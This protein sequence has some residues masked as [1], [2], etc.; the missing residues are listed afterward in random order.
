MYKKLLLPLSIKASILTPIAL[1]SASDIQNT[2]VN[3]TT[4]WKENK[5]YFYYETQYNTQMAP[6]QF[7]QWLKGVNGKKTLFQM[8][9]PGTHDS[10]A[11]AGNWNAFTWAWTKTQSM[12]FTQQLNAGIRAFDLRSHANLKLAHGP[13]EM[14]ASFQSALLEMVDFLKKNPSEFIFF[15][16]KDDGFDVK[17]QQNV[18]E[19]ASKYLAIL[20]SDEIYPYLFNPTGI[21]FPNL[22]TESFRLDNLRGKIVIANF[23]YHSIQDKMVELQKNFKAN[24]WSGGFDYWWAF[25]KKPDRTQD[26][27]NSSEEQKYQYATAFMPN[28]NNAP[29]DT[30]NLYINFLSVANG[31]RPPW[32]AESLNPRFNQFFI[33]NQQ[34]HKMGLVYADFPGPSLIENIFKTNYYVTNEQLKHGYELPWNNK[35]TISKPLV[36]DNKITVYGDNLQGYTIEVNEGNNK[37][38]TVTI[39]ENVKQKTIDLGNSY[40]LPLNLDLAVTGYRKT[41]ENGFYPSRKYNVITTNAKIQNTT[42]NQQSQELTSKV[43]QYINKLKSTFGINTFSTYL[44]AQYLNKLQQYIR[45]SEQNASSI[46]TL[47]MQFDKEATKLDLLIQSFNQFKTNVST[48]IAQNN[49]SLLKILNQTLINSLNNTF[50]NY[51]NIIYTSI[52]SSAIDYDDLFDYFDEYLNFLNKLKDNIFYFDNSLSTYLAYLKENL[53]FKDYGI[54]YWLQ[55]EQVVKN[56]LVDFANLYQNKSFLNIN[57]ISRNITQSI[58]TLKNNLQIVQNDITDLNALQEQYNLKDNQLMFFITD[59]KKDI[60]TPKELTT[61][62]QN[63]IAYANDITKANTLMQDLAVFEVKYNFASKPTQLKNKYKTQILA[64]NNAINDASNPIAP[65]DLVEKL[66][67]I[68]TIRDEIVETSSYNE[69]VDALSIFNEQKTEFKKQIDQYLSENNNSQAEAVLNEAKEIEALN[70]LN[71]TSENFLNTLNANEKN[72]V[73]EIQ[74]VTNV[75]DFKT[76]LDNINALSEKTTQLRSIMINLGTF[77]SY[78]NLGVFAN[79]TQASKYQAIFESLN[80]TLNTSISLSEIQSAIET[81]TSTEEDIKDLVAAKIREIRTQIEKST[82]LYNYQK[83][84]LTDQL[85]NIESSIDSLDNQ[86]LQ[87]FITELTKQETLNLPQKD[88][89][90]LN[91]LSDTQYKAWYRALNDSENETQYIQ[92]LEKAKEFNTLIGT[93]KTRLQQLENTQSSNSAAVSYADS[94]TQSNLTNALQQAKAALTTATGKVALEQAINTYDTQLQNIITAYNNALSSTKQELEQLVQ[95]VTNYANNTLKQPEYKTIQT[96]LLEYLKSFKYNDKDINDMTTKLNALKQE[97]AKIQSNK[98][99]IDNADK[100]AQ[101]KQQVLSKIEELNTLLNSINNNLLSNPKQSISQQLITLK[102]QAEA[103]DVTYSALQDIQ[104]KLTPLE[105]KINTIKTLSP[106]MTT[107]SQELNTYLQKASSFEGTDLNSIKTQYTTSIN[108]LISTLNSYNSDTIYTTNETSLNNLVVQA[109]SIYDDAIA[110]KQA[111]QDLLAKKQTFIQNVNTLITSINNEQYN[112]VYL[113]NKS[114]LDSLLQSANDVTATSALNVLQVQ[115]DSLVTSINSEKT[116]VDNYKAFETKLTQYEAKASEFDGENY[117]NVKTTYQNALSTIKSKLTLNFDSNTLTS[118]QNQLD[119]TYQNAVEQKTQ[120][121]TQFNDKKAKY[122]KEVQDTIVSVNNDTY[123]AVYE[124]VQQQLNDALNSMQQATT[125]NDLN[126]AYQSYQTLLN[127]IKADTTYV[128]DYNNLQTE[129][130]TYRAKAEEF[131][132]PNLSDI[133]QEYLTKLNEL[134][135]TLKFD[136]NQQELDKIAQGLSKAYQDAINAKNAI[137]PETKPEKPMTPPTSGDSNNNDQEVKKSNSALNWLW[138]L[139]IIPTFGLG[140]LAYVLITKKK[141]KK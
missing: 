43:L 61:S 84:A 100:L 89:D 127:S 111:L 79:E 112:A 74:S 78:K 64:L 98:E 10:A 109:K 38:A 116:Y 106:V 14:D 57:S 26:N 1:L 69:Q 62:K 82:K 70:P 2:T 29:F 55:Q 97:Y 27:Y 11:Y 4:V 51:K 119:R 99:A 8:S 16:I 124:K 94:Q 134:Q 20:S 91:N 122:V 139:M 85:N 25:S 135:S 45:P 12:T 19:A 67:E 23:W 71:I 138:L 110:Q 105:T 96:A 88:K 18:L 17:N 21:N 33:N 73:T 36:N 22:S 50:S 47:S 34:Y 32:T 83:L 49:D 86:Q 104:T 58:D 121:T 125:F 60:E 13:I 63:I 107:V 108:K 53:K 39:N 75:Q 87:N 40:Y 76:K 129:F 92:H 5:S 117:T 120:I 7:N 31:M 15:R 56:K 42:Q 128:D 46:R 103:Q 130:E 113:K 37:L 41:I 136:F 44:N 102:T 54:T 115:Y 9:L 126:T 24:V 137:E 118:L 65:E 68:N 141:N 30:R 80:N 77:D 6:Y 93:E 3:N 28:P 35:L 48:F 59:I 133:K 132:A 140:Y 52:T 81:A 131:N 114:S 95:T 123:K 72:L 90:E 66:V 101:L